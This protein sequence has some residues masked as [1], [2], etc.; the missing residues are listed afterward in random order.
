MECSVLLQPRQDQEPVDA[1]YF[2][3][4]IDLSALIPVLASYYRRKPEYPLEAMLRLLAYR[5]LRGHLYLTSLWRE[6]STKPEL[7][8]LLGFGKVPS[9][10][11]LWHFI[12]VRLKAEGVERLRFHLIK[13]IHDAMN[14]YGVRMGFDG[15]SDATPIASCNRDAAYNGF[16]EVTCYLT[17]KV[18]DAA[19]GLTLAWLLTPGD[20]DEGGLLVTLLCRVRG[21]GFRLRRLYADNGY[22]SPWNY[23][24]LWLMRTR[25]WIGF[26]RNAKPGWRGKPRTLRLRY[27]KKVTGRLKVNVRTL[28]LRK[29][30]MGLMA[31]GQEEYVGAYIRNHSHAEYKRNKARWLK[32]YRT[33]RNRIEA[34]NGHQKTWLRLDRT[35]AKKLHTATN[36]VSLIFLTEAIVAYGRIMNGRATNLTGVAQFT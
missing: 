18:L 11:A 2:L 31:H 13:L 15:V 29:L 22:S 34:S 21:L 35:P 30:L 16:Y 20:V 27:R 14:S 25:P 3:S 33:N 10:Q 4:L 8:S 26:R 36:H 28:S 17:H 12:N 19:T 23:A 9:Y 32:R 7:V 5:V 24:M 6:L 1:A